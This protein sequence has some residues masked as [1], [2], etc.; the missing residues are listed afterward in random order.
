MDFLYDRTRGSVHGTEYIRDLNDEFYLVYSRSTLKTYNDTD[1]VIEA[2]Y[3]EENSLYKTLSGAIKATEKLPFN[4][5]NN[6]LCINHGL[7]PYQIIAYNYMDYI[8]EP[9]TKVFVNCYDAIKENEFK[10]LVELKSKYCYGLG[11]KQMADIYSMIK[12]KVDGNDYDD[13]VKRK[14]LK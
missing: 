12:Y 14:K 7:N 9:T 5:R 11:D 1:E 3:I 10:F 2:L 4:I 13:I 8:Y 6:S